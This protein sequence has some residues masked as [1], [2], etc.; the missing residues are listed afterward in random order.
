M[1]LHVEGSGAAVPRF[2]RSEIAAFA[3]LCVR[4]A[5]RSGAA[6]FRAGE[7]SIA[8]VDDG[9]M[10]RLNTRFR[11]R[12][13]TTDVLTFPSGIAEKGAPLGDIA[14]SVEQARRQARQERH[15]LATELRYLILHGVLHAYGH[16]HETDEGVMN[17]LEIRLR[18]RLGLE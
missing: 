14:I 12:R 9:E 7:L 11:G 8:L 13:K 18:K 1:A 17:D 5:E 10:R 4:A 16:D 6:T 3:A 2:S 15:S